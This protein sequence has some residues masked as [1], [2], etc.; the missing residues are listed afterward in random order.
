MKVSTTRECFRNVLNTSQIHSLNTLNKYIRQIHCFLKKVFKYIYKKHILIVMPYSD[1][2]LIRNISGL[3][4][5][6]KSDS[7]LNALIEIVDK[8][9]DD[10]TGKIWNEEEEDYQMIRLASALLA[11]WLASLSLAGGKEKAKNFKSEGFEILDTLVRK[12]KIA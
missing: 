6:E 3:T 2:T 7:D 8:I 10:Y 9:I 12:G 5:T 1:I 4:T 11:S